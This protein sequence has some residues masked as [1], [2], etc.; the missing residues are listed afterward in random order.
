MGL[1]ASLD[2]IPSDYS[3]KYVH[4]LIPSNIAG[5]GHQFKSNKARTIR[6]KIAK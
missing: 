6:V 2:V 4:S 5:L 1:M 3:I